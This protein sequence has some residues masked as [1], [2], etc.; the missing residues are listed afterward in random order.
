[1]K[2]A[3]ISGSP[4]RGGNSEALLDRALEGAVVAGASIEKI[5]LNELD[6]KPCQE[7]GGCDAT[8]ACVLGDDM[9]PLY[10]TIESADA[11]IVVTPVFFGSVS[12]QLKMMIDRFQCRWMAKY[13]INKTGSA[14]R[15]RRGL[16]LCVS[17]SHRKDFFENAKAIVR[18]LFACLDID[19]HGEQFCV[20]IEK[21]DDI[22]ND[23][24]S[25]KKAFELGRALVK[26]A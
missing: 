4:R 19:Y 5:V 14:G 6:F 3:G 9:E 22:K 10:R 2:V 23:A 8:G 24:A 16:F 7:C 1:M 13:V 18:N 21:K 12:A 11:L 25:L 15:R 20:G 17:G 26:D